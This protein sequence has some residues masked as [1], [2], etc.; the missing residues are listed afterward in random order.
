MLLD[1][2]ALLHVAAIGRFRNFTRAAEALGIST[3]AL[4]KSIHAIERSLDAPLFERSRRGVSPTV[5]GEVVLAGAGP[6]IRGVEHILEE[7]RRV[8]GLETGT[9][10][11][12]AGPYPLEL[13]VATAAFRLA[14]RHP[15]LQL[16][17]FH[18]DWEMLTR[19]VLDGTLDVAVAELTAASQVPELTTEVVG[20]HGGKF[21]CRAEHP[22]AARPT[23]VF[24]DL[25]GFPTVG[26]PTPRRFS[27]LFSRVAA[28]GRVE[29]GSGLF[30][31]AITVDSVD[32]MKEAVRQTDAIAWAPTRL[33][34]EELRAGRFVA[35]PFEPAG[36]RLNY[37]FIRRAD[38]PMTPAL[39]S[40]LTEV[41][42]VEKEISGAAPPAR[43]RRH[44]K[45][46]RK[47]AAS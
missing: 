10:S 39:D 19:R 22:L 2:R 12:G 38:R 37:G 42:A 34:A 5:F 32:L 3:P 27:A 1:L 29:L 35:L 17:L 15:S 23:A 36:A 7:L 9:I 24:E 20:T 45:R 13:S 41:R 14:R 4:S 8:R 46:A 44:G 28:S 18:G 33:I 21:Y 40:F 25:L 6:A 26:P 31:P 11:V 43:R 47:T 16:R 30:L